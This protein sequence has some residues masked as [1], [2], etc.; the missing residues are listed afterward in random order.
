MPG[1]ARSFRLLSKREENALAV[2]LNDEE[3]HAQH[4]GGPE[5]DAQR[6]P[7]HARFACAERLRGKRRDG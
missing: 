7:H 2:E 5:A 6:A 3:R 4:H 1:K